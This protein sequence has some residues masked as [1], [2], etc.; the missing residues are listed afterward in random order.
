MKLRNEMI[1]GYIDGIVLS[2]LSK[3][4]AYGYEISKTVHDETSGQFDLKEGKLC[5]FLS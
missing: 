1:K 4:D 2:V 3:Q 5:P